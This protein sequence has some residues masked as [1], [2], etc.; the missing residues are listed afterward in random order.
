M[1]EEREVWEYDQR[2]QHRFI[3]H[4]GRGYLCLLG[5]IHDELMHEL[6]E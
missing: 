3:V 1:T 4:D 2:R 5:M 6:I